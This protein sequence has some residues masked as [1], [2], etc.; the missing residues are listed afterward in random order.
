MENMTQ[1]IR[2][3]LPKSCYTSLIADGDACFYT[4]D[5]ALKIHCR[6]QKKYT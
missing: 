1:F 3:N 2:S 4:K 6:N 5:L